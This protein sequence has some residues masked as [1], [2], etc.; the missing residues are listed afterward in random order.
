VLA[1][2]TDGTGAPQPP[3]ENGSFPKGA[4]GYHR[5]HIEV[6]PGA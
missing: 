6:L 5:A 3:E 1:R 4:T 2:A